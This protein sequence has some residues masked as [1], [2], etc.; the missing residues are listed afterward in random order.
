M[1]FLFH[2]G[3]QNQVANQLNQMNHFFFGTAKKEPADNNAGKT[4]D[5]P[6][7]ALPPA[8]QSGFP[9]KCEFPRG[10]SLLD[11]SSLAALTRSLD[12]TNNITGDDKTTTPSTE[13]GCLQR[14]ASQAA[15]LSSTFLSSVSAAPQSESDASS[16]GTVPADAIRHL[17]NEQNI[18]KQRL[19]RKAELA[20]LS[21]RRKKMKLS[22]LEDENRLLKNEISRLQALRAHDQELLARYQKEQP[23]IAT[24]PALKIKQQ[25]DHS[26]TYSPQTS[27][28]LAQDIVAQLEAIKKKLASA[29]N[30]SLNTGANPV[31]SQLHLNFLQWILNQKDQ[32]YED[33]SGLWSSLFGQELVCTPEQLHL[34]SQLREHS[35]TVKLNSSQLEAILDQLKLLVRSKIVVPTQ[36]DQ[37][38]SILSPAQ[39]NG[40]R[41]WIQQFGHI[42]IKINV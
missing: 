30:V 10:P 27:G 21:R 22:D 26:A 19:A 7:P 4:R 31:F 38:V 6:P 37:I 18:K 42:C 24:S 12:R 3:Q 9:L 15:Y 40:L 11:N 32:F 16:S 1:S 25:V 41:R 23:H 13:T 17:L 28:S 39:L 2:P 34:L 14:A 8:E 5:V 20:R 36:L 33:P 29:D 35:K